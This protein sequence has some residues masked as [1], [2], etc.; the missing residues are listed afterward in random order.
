MTPC[1][2]EEVLRRFD[3]WL[4][5]DKVM[6]DADEINAWA[7]EHPQPFNRDAYLGLYADTSHGT[8]EEPHTKLIQSLAKNELKGGHHGPMTSMG[9]PRDELPSWDD[10]QRR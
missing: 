10:L 6:V 2:N 4:D 7:L 5:G 8:A 9:V 1:A 3:A